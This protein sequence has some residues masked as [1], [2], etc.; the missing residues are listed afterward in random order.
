MLSTMT[1]R[2][3]VNVHDTTHDRPASGVRF[4][5]YW[6]DLHSD[7]LLKSGCTDARGTTPQPLLD[8]TKISAGQYRLVLHIGDYFEEK[9]LPSARSFIDVLPLTFVIEDASEPLHLCIRVSPTGYSV[10]RQQA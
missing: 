8:S 3:T 1:A 5:L 6:V 7:I 4:Q 10:E 9:S 2:L